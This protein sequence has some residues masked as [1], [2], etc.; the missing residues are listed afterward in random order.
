METTHITHPGPQKNSDIIVISAIEE[1]DNKSDRPPCPDCG[2]Q[3]IISRGED[4]MCRHCNR[5]FKKK[6]R[7]SNGNKTHNKT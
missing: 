3:Y 2:S 6:Y 7:K 4:W 1:V 5:K